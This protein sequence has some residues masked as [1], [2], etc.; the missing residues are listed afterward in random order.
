MAIFGN[1]RLENTVQV[2]DKTRLDAVSSFTTDE[3]DVTLVEIEPEAAAGFIDI[4][5]SPATDNALYFLDW[6]YSTDG[7]KT[8]SL[9][10]TT[11]GVP[12]TFTDT[13]IVVTAVN[14]ALLSNDADLKT[15]EPCIL[16]YIQTGRNSYLDVHRRA[17]DLILDWLWENN[18]RDNN[19]DRYT[20]AALVA[21]EQFRKWSTYIVLKLIHEGLSNAVD[22]LFAVVIGKGF[23]VAVNFFAG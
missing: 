13:I 3:A 19:R 8:V 7:T 11:D 18:F 6:E 15:H 23:V 21:K 17:R 4:T 12:V 14:D 2:D 5:P 1:L 10:I 16:D 9:R 20:A 22:D